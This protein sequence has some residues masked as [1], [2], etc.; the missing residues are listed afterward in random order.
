MRIRFG[1]LMV[2]TMYDWLYDLYICLVIQFWSLLFDLFI[3]CA[4]FHYFRPH[5]ALSTYSKQ[6]Y[7]KWILNKHGRVSLMCS[8]ILRY[9]EMTVPIGDELFTI[10][11]NLFKVCCDWKLNLDKLPLVLREYI[12]YYAYTYY[13]YQYWTR[14]E[15]LSINIS[16]TLARNVCCVAFSIN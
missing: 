7:Y 3:L 2:C 4:M 14:N 5:I 10:L 15:Q 13:I 1:I 9:L 11:H 8:M 6:L 16:L 12:I